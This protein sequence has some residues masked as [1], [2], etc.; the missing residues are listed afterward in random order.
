[1]VMGGAVTTDSVLAEQYGAKVKEIIGNI[2]KVQEGIVAA[3]HRPAGEGGRSTRCWRSAR[4]CWLPLAKTWDLKGAGDVVETQ[5]YADEGFT[6]LV[7]SLP[8]GTGCICRH[9]D[10]VRSAAIRDPCRSLAAAAPRT[11]CRASWPRH[12]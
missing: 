12:C 10:F 6:L 8:Q 4:P 9:A 2:N 1:M 5:R 3:D 7:G 11:P